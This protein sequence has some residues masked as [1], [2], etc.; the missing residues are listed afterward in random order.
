MSA[1]PA[2]LTRRR[3]PGLID[4][5]INLPNAARMYDYLLGGKDHYPA[6]RAAAEELLRI[7]PEARRLACDNRAFLGRAARF[8]LDSGIRQFLDLGSGLPTKGNLAEAVHAHCPDARTVHVD[9]DRMVCTHSRAL[10]AR[11]D[12]AAVIEGDLRDITGIVGDPHVRALIDFREPVAI[13]LTAVLHFLTDDQEVAETV[14]HYRKLLG[15]GGHLVITHGTTGALPASRR[16]AGERVYARSS[17]PARMRGAKEVAGYFEGLQMVEPGLLDV[18]RWRPDGLV[19]V[20]VDGA[21]M[22]GGIGRPSGGG[23]M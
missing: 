1:Y 2:P 21:A 8:L 6:D 13:V 23:T 3:T 7:A 9:I 12:R 18:A 20:N 17:S 5:D 19:G 4:L 16:E 22:I 11:R 10:I 15:P 14:R